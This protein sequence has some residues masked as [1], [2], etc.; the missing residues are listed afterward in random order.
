MKHILHVPKKDLIFV[1]K[2]LSQKK[3]TDELSRFSVNVDKQD[4]EHQATARFILA[5]SSSFAV[6]LTLSEAST[7]T[8]LE[9]DYR[10]HIML[11]G[12]ARHC[13]QGNKNPTT[14]S[15]LIRA[16]QSAVEDRICEVNTLR[17]AIS[18]AAQRKQPPVIDLTNT[19]K[20]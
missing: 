9:P 14:H 17:T 1:H 18:K 16:A 2:L 6:G 20:G 3:I 10:L 5:T 4:I 19:V 13:R 7:V 15:W 11:Q 12:F 8:F